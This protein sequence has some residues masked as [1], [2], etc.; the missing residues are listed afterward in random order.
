MDERV[1]EPASGPAGEATS[2]DPVATLRRWEDSG[3]TWRRLD[4]GGPTV[5]LSLCTCTGGEEVS[6]LVSADPALVAYLDGRWASD[7]E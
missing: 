7:Q 5:R 4:A 3:G 6:R 2:G 1:D